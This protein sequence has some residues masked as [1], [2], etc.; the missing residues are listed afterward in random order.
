MPEHAPAENPQDREYAPVAE[1]M[2]KP[3]KSERQNREY[4]TA[5]T[6]R[7]SMNATKPDPIKP[8]SG[9]TFQTVQRLPTAGADNL[10]EQ[11]CIL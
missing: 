4:F 1:S 6:I 8:D 7:F 5:N 10:C 9:L 2:V 11:R 3:S